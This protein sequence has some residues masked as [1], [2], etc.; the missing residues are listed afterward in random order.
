MHFV[1]R[2]RRAAPVAYVPAGHPAFIAP[3]V[4]QVPYDRR[5]PRRLLRVRGIRIRLVS[6][7]SRHA[8]MDV[9]LVKRAVLDA[10]D[11]TFPDPRLLSWEEPVRR[12]VPT[13]EVSDHADRVRVRSPD[14]ERRPIGLGGQMRA[15]LVEE[16][17]VRAFVEQVQVERA[18][19]RARD[20]AGVTTSRMPRSGMRTQSGRMFSS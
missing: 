16:M 8:R 3:L 12:L 14:G 2:P 11:E 17:A 6:S 1:N 7:G 5:L 13:V 19:Q 10:R 20:H 15:Q 4:A 18:E 9:V